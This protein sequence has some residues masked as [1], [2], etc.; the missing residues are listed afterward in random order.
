[1]IVKV[2]DETE[3]FRMEDLIEHLKKS[4]YLDECG[5]VF[6]FEGIVRGVDDKKTEK[7]VL[8]T[9]DPKRTQ[10]GLEEIVEDVKK[11]Y[12]VRDVAVVHYIGEFYTSDTLFMVAVA[13]PHRRETLDAMAEIIER[14]KHELDFQKEEYTDS[15]K[16]IIMSGG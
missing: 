3:S 7:L 12:P 15:G 8:R 2:T 6:T 1:M 16:N 9:P 10:K 13:G 14:T 11:K 4:P 5:A